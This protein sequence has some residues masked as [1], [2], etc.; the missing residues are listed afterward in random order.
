MFIFKAKKIVK[1]N[2]LLYAPIFE[3]INVGSKIIVDFPLFL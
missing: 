1:N 3:G 2:P